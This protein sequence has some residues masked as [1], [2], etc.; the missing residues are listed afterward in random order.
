MGRVEEVGACV[1]E[2]GAPRGCG[3]GDAETEEA[4]R[5]FREN[6]SGHADGGLHDER[7]DDVRKDVTEKDAGIG[8]AEGSGCLDEL[9]LTDGHDLGSDEARVADP[10]GEGEGD[11]QVDESWAKE[12]HEGDGKQD[13]RKR[14]EGVGDVDI[15]DGVGEAAIETGQCACGKTDGDGQGDDRDCDGEGD[16][17]AKKDAGEDIA[18]EFIRT[19]QM[20]AAG[21]QH[22]SLE[23]EM[24]GITGSEDGCKDSGAE[25]ADQEDDSASRKGL[26]A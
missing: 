16:A 8:G 9:A 25:E 24:G 20:A 18:T 26:A 6:G 17:R 21:W 5:G 22:A 13:A 15:E 2:H 11:D 14:E 19:E 10:T 3:R 7:L 23:V 1:I 4:E 12:G